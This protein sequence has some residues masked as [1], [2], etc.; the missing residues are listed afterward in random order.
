MKII[1]KYISKSILKINGRKH[2]SKY[3]FICVLAFFCH[4]NLF[5]QTDFRFGL[6]IHPNLSF[7]QSN[8]SNMLRDKNFS[9]RN[10]LLGF[11]L[12]LNPSFQIDNWIFEF[13]S[14]LNSNRT[15]VKFKSESNSAFVDLQT[16]S[17]TNE[18]NIGYRIFSSD[19]PYFEF[20]LMPNFSHSF[21]A[22]QRLRTKGEFHQYDNFQAIFPDIN[23]TWQTWN[24]GLGFKVRTQLK[25][26]R[27]LDYGLS[28]RYSTTKYP[29]IGM[30]FTDGNKEIVKII[31]PNVYTLNIDFIYYFGKKKG[32]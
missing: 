14:N 1:K 5:S 17:F 9:T 6:K 7:S 21:V 13:S 4:C 8:Q 31:K 12:G 2:V 15:G 20:F 19:E 32:I 28:Y 25:N 22:V 18:I 16:V 24:L 11:N 30:R 29:E 23:K 3:A 10:G 27:R 26:L